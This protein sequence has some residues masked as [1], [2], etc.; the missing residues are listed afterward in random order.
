M[1]ALTVASL[2]YNRGHED[3]GD[4]PP[5]H[6]RRLAPDDPGREVADRSLDYDHAK[7]EIYGGRNTAR[8][9]RV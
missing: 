9:T 1:A 7:L 2:S 3:A 6:G 5:L 8:R 4:A